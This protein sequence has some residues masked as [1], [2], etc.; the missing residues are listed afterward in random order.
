M[1]NDIFLLI[2]GFGLLVKGADWLV[3]G[4]SFFYRGSPTFFLANDKVF[5]SASPNRLSRF[6]G[7]I[8]LVIFCLSIIFLIN[9]LNSH[10]FACIGK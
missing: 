5:N 6:D 2:A 7:I 4:S 8:I 9:K 1:L 3:D 10:G